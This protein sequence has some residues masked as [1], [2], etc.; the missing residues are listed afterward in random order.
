MKEYLIRR[1]QERL[2]RNVQTNLEYTKAMFIVNQTSR[3]QVNFV[4]FILY[5]LRIIG[6]YVVSYALNLDA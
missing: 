2:R 4:I 5:I 3:K 6:I 1:E